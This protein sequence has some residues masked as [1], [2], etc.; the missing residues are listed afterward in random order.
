[1]K[2]KFYSVI[3]GVINNTFLQG[4]DIER[5]K[6]AAQQSVCAI[7][8]S[9]TSVSRHQSLSQVQCHGPILSPFSLVEGIKFSLL[10]LNY[11]CVHYS[12]PSSFI[13]RSFNISRDRHNTDNA[14]KLLLAVEVWSPTNANGHTTSIILRRQR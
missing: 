6:N 4:I 11:S 1:M 5:Y 3:S 9:E 2:D 10:L 8:K 14:F 13:R 12:V 7:N